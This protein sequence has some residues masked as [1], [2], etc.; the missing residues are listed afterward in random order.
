MLPLTLAVE[1]S[2]VGQWDQSIYRTEQA[3]RLILKSCTE[4]LGR[5]R[6]VSPALGLQIKGWK[7]TRRQMGKC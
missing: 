7:K 1:R 4:A 3:V 2:K 5:K 6:I